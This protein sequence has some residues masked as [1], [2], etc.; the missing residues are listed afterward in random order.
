MRSTLCSWEHKLGGARTATS[1]SEGSE[2]AVMLVPIGNAPLL[3]RVTF[4]ISALQEFLAELETQ[5]KYRSRSIPV[6]TTTFY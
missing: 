1:Q 4:P 2:V 5:M 6:K 3:R